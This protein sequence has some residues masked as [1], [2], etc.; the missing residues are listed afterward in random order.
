MVAQISSPGISLDSGNQN[1]PAPL[2]IITPA[3]GR[4][5]LVS[6]PIVVN[7]VELPSSVSGIPVLESTPG[8]TLSKPV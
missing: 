7:T 4:I 6:V 1:S 3:E 8:T 5:V 2:G